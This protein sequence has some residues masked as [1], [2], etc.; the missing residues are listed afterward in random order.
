MDR[1]GLAFLGVLLAASS[2]TR[3]FPSAAARQSSTQV[4]RV[5]E[6]REPSDGSGPWQPVR[7]YFRVNTHDAAPGHE[8][9]FV[10]SPVTALIATVPD[11]EKTHLSLY[12]DRSIESLMWAISDSGYALQG[13]WLPWKN[14]APKELLLLK[15]RTQSEEQVRE[16]HKQPGLLLFRPRRETGQRTPLAVFIVG[17]T[18]TSGIDL[19]VLKTTFE[20]VVALQNKSGASK[21]QFRI[22]GPTYSG[23]FARLADFLNVELQ[24]AALSVTLASGTAT[25][26]QSIESFDAA[27]KGLGNRVTRSSTVQNDEYASRHFLDYVRNRWWVRHEIAL[28]SEDDTAYG[29]LS[30]ELKGHEEVLLVRYPREIARVRNARR[31]ETELAPVDHKGERTAS[32]QQNVQF[33][34]RDAGVDGNFEQDAVPAFSTQ[35]TP[36]SQEAALLAISGA[37]RR[38]N[39]AM[40]GILATDILDAVFLGRFLRKACPETRIFTFDADLLLVRPESTSFAGV[41]SVTSY[42][43]FSRNQHWTVKERQ[44]QPPRRVQFSSRYAEGV[45]NACRLVTDPAPNGRGERLLE[46][47][48]PNQETSKGPPLWLT[49]VGREHYW[50]VALLDNDQTTNQST[51]SLSDLAN[52]PVEPLHPEPPSLAWTV[53]FCLVVLVAL[54]HLI[55]TA[56]LLL[57]PGRDADSIL[58]LLGQRIQTRLQ[59]PLS[60]RVE[61]L[62]EVKALE[63]LTVIFKAYPPF[64]RAPNVRERTFL[65]CLT[66]F[67]FTAIFLMFSCGVRILLLG[68][69]TDFRWWVPLA[70]GV[71]ILIMLLLLSLW[72]TL[73][74]F[75]QKPPSDESKKH[76]L[77]VVPVVALAIFICG[78]WWSFLSDRPQLTKV[79]MVVALI[80]PAI[81]VTLRARRRLIVGT[82]LLTLFAVAF[83]VWYFWPFS[84]SA[85]LPS[86]LAGLFI[87]Y[88]SLHLGNGVAPVLPILLVVGGFFGWGWVQLNRE[89][90]ITPARAA[91]SV[92]AALYP[93]SKVNEFDREV[94]ASRTRV[95]EVIEDYFSERFWTSALLFFAL[96]L[97]VFQPWFKVRSIESIYY[98]FAY[99]VALLALHWSI[100]ITWL[101]FY[102]TWKV[103]KDYLQALER[104]PLHEAFS[105]LEKQ[106]KWVPLGRIHERQLFISTK[107]WEVLRRL[108][109]FDASQLSPQDHRR[110]TE[111]QAALK[112]EADAIDSMMHAVQEDLPKGSPDRQRYSELQ[113]R[114]EVASKIISKSFAEGVWKNGASDALQRA[115][116]EYPTEKLD[117]TDEAR[118]IG[119]EYIAL[120]HLIFLRYVFRHLRNLLGFLAG[121]FI[122]AVI[123][124][125]SYPFRGERWI[126]Y[127]SVIGLVAIGAG[128]AVVFAQMDRD[129]VLSRISETKVNEIGSSFYLRLAQFGALPLLTVLAGQFPEINS[130]FFSWVRPA[131]EALK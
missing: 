129:A 58:S 118:I 35:Q 98:D 28:L 69:P 7:S 124:V 85:D 108:V 90:M 45:Y 53:I 23:S 76:L 123:S 103:F 81:C 68:P 119:E 50:P 24:N 5:E 93:D 102:V 92:I 73:L 126:G 38:E 89:H 94:M 56:V 70:V 120:R 44:G 64:E 46:Y 48:R 117:K 19:A 106:I 99:L 100:C 105:R 39:A 60:A 104:H 26:L 95:N 107:N 109:T 17:E 6:S 121:G 86:T 37:I 52:C 20:H 43:L 75:T 14:K 16:R 131:L 84:D 88:R 71:V 127:S 47:C 114:F 27:V 110:L 29:E 42:P 57:G 101:Q 21:Y 3:T 65:L 51:I 10:T 41:L 112:D 79:L 87:A 116:K 83:G 25:S 33:S 113:A 67:L 130:L 63:R 11:P 61:R 2:A 78:M 9:D 30:P 13:F 4:V 80:L 18:P 77:I 66:V 62:R 32:E 128:I 15:D 36:A 111:L 55:C 74:W 125:N 72:M 22:V 54:L 91:K 31:E 34:L 59:K 8:W 12:F 49:V 96:W 1:K 82:W 115:R 40:A 122:V 97:L